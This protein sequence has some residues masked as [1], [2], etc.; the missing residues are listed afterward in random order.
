MYC[1]ELDQFFGIV[2]APYREVEITLP[3]TILISVIWCTVA[4]KVSSRAQHCGRESLI[5]CEKS[6][7]SRHGDT[8]RQYQI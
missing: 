5:A 7:Q 4:E 1:N 6:C 8:E 3:W 2:G